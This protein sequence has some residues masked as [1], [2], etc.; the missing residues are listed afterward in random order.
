VQHEYRSATIFAVSDTEFVTIAGSR[1]PGA[2]LEIRI[3][4]AILS[5]QYRN[6]TRERYE[7]VP[8]AQMPVGVNIYGVRWEFFN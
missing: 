1:V 6:F 5:Y 7:L 4:S 3:A 2:L 8:G